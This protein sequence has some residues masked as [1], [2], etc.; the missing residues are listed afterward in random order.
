MR[1]NQINSSDVGI[2][3][4]EKPTQTRKIRPTRRSVSGVY[5][6]RGEIAVPFEST[7]ERDFLIR[8]EYFTSVVDVISQPVQVPFVDSNNHKNIYT[9]DF[10]VYRHLGD[11]S[12]HR[13]PKPQL[14]EVKPT[15][16]WQQHWR[17]WLPKW[18]AARRLAKENGW[19]FRIYDES[20][21]R[22][23]TLENI[24]FL[25]RFKRTDYPEE[26]TL[27]ILQTIEEMGSV[28]FHY[29]LAKHF[30]GFDRGVG[31]A[32]LWHLL[33]VRRAECNIDKKLCN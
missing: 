3:N 18:K 20:R 1:L 10:L 23:Q 28:P 14:I 16:E 15:S 22:D 32:H 33:A 4:C 27:M 12:Y 29:L 6:F 30:T 11:L 9:P 17:K 21:I 8:S 5:S 26:E 25:E 19:E 24:R 31:V 7:L 13:Y 2:D